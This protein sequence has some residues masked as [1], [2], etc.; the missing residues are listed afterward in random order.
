[1]EFGEELFDK[2]DELNDLPTYEKLYDA[3]K[4]LHHAWMKIGKRNSCPERKW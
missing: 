4:E 3:F 1:M 2:F